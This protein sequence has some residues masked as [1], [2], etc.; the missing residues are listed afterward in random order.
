MGTGM[1][2]GEAAGLRWR[3]V[4]LADPDGPIVTIEE[5]FVRHGTDTPTSEA[6][7]R[8]IALGE[9]V[10]AEFWEHRARAPFTSDDDLVFANPRTGN[11]FDAGRYGDRFRLAVRRAGIEESVRPSHDLRH[12]SITNA[13]AAGMSPGA[14]MS[15]AGHSSFT[16]TQR[17]IEL[18]GER[19]REEAQRLEKD[20]GR[21][22]V[23]NGGTKA[24]TCRHKRSRR[25]PLSR[26][27][28]AAG[29]GFEPTRR[30]HA[31]RFSRPP[32]STA[33]APRRGAL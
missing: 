4:F 31:Q 17:Y 26:V 29:V 20:S 16:R 19:F 15:R 33:P 23:P 28:K 21:R 13:A 32:R 30:L 8:T 6:G 18:A 1:R 27:G 24:V 5:T 10:A 11:H 7:Y 22:P 3:S 14:V 2:W 25:K 9:K 12:S